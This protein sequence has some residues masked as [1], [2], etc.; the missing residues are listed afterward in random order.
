V[1]RKLRLDQSK[2]YDRSIAMQEIALMLTAFING[3]N[4]TKEIGSEQGGIKHWDDFI[5]HRENGVLE[6]L[7]VK[8]QTTPFSDEKVERGLISKGDKKDSPKPL[9][10]LDEAI[11][12]LRQWVELPGSASA[13]PPR[14]FKLVVPEGTVNIK[15]DLTMTQLARL[16]NEE[17]NKHST[18]E[19]F[20][21]LIQDDPVTKRICDWLKSWCGFKDHETIL[22]A[23]KL[24][25]VNITGDQTNIEADIAKQLDSCFNNCNDVKAIINQ[26]FE[27][28][29][30]YTTSITPRAVHDAVR[31]YLLPS[32]S[33]WTQYTYS[34]DSWEVSGTHDSSGTIEHP[35]NTVPHLWNSQINGVLKLN[36]K[37][38]PSPVVK[39]II[40]LVFHMHNLPLAHLNDA[41]AWIEAAKTFVGGTLGTHSEDCVSTEIRAIDSQSFHES[42]DVR[43][44]ESVDDQDEEA[45]QLNYEMNNL[46]WVKLRDEVTTKISSLNKSPLRTA[47]DSRWNAWKSQF[48]ASPQ[49]R[50]KLLCSMLSLKAEGSDIQ[51]EMRLGLKTVRYL[52]DGLFMLL[53]V[54]VALNDDDFGWENFGNDLS[55]TACALSC[56]AGPAEYRGVRKLTD[57]GTDRLL[58]QESSKILILSQVETSASDFVGASMADSKITTDTLA[59]PHKP[60]IVFTNSMKLRSI[61]RSGDLDQLKTYLRTEIHNAMTPK[62]LT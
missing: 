53:V 16:C 10:E 57:D 62:S 44:I 17:V 3:R 52:K 13:S 5:I 46:T 22:A 59:D 42:S 4:H 28:N 24:L 31:A 25:K 49:H 8:K 19:K 27:D 29:A 51:A 41:E 26:F 32:V 50:Q 15:E 20:N 36:S 2:K 54:S 12:S 7:Q 34:N 47:L 23:L 55:V 9:S 48:D 18:I 58:G 30:T 6:H 37:R 14:L 39:A 38:H 45:E 1:L 35:K 43:K 11:D 21:Q 60:P 40:R 61:I 56:W 33:G